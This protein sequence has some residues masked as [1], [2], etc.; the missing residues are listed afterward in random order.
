MLFLFVAKRKV[1][2]ENAAKEGRTP[3]FV[4]WREVHDRS[5]LIFEEFVLGDKKNQIMDLR[6]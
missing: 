6:E 5:N 2:T 3:R 1:P 4:G